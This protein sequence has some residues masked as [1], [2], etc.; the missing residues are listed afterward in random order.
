MKKIS[1]L[2]YIALLG[3][4]FASCEESI[5][6][7]PEQSLSEEVT[8][9]NAAGAEAALNAVYSQAQLLEVFGSGP[10]IFEDLMA[11]NTEFVGSFPTI[12]DVRNYVTTTPNVTVQGH[13]QVM[14]RVINGANTVIDRVPTINDPALTDARKEQIIG[15]AKFMRAIVY[16]QLVNQ[17]AQPYN[18]GNGSSPGVPLV[19]A[20]FNG[21]P[22][23]PARATVAEV[24]NQIIKD[25]TEALAAVPATYAGT[26][27]RGRAT[28]GAAA[29]YLSRIH[30][31]RGEYAQAAAFAKQVLDNTATYSIATNYGFYATPGAEHVFVILNSATDNGRT[32]SGGWASYHRPANQGGRGDAAFTTELENA[33]KE[34]EGDKRYTELSDQVTA[35]DNQNRRMTRK[36]VD[37]V[38]NAD[39]AP[40]MRT[41]EMALNRAEALAEIDGVNQESIT[42]VN[43]IRVRAGLAPWT[44]DQFDS[45]EALVAAI[46]NERR[47]ELAFEGHRRMDLLRRG[48]ALRSSGP[49]A[50]IAGFGAD[51]TIL[52]IPQRE[53]D[54]NKSL[55]QNPGY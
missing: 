17:F 18:R 43:P 3:V 27:L 34:E 46:L 22:E 26:G 51:R 36:F 53:I 33:Y 38:T 54:L 40:L 12:Q 20:G 25:L 31:Y 4:F 13:W 14:Y 2:F 24:H 55:T 50:P 15:Q 45:K 9:S 1:Y 41:S 23:S 35:A 16:F 11:D 42:L 28:K 19:L 32:G 29:G 10:Q 21:T 8:F 7:N 47:K 48:Q 39:P 6:L 44:I 5:L 37:A 30:L 49:Q 52:P